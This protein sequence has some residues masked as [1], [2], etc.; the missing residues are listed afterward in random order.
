MIEMLSIF[1]LPKTSL[2]DAVSV[3]CSSETILVKGRYIKLT[4]DVSQTPWNLNEEDDD[5]GAGQPNTNVH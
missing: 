5:D 2:V 3:K 1:K 4:R